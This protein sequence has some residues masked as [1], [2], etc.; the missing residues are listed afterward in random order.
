MA[1]PVA[2]APSRAVVLIGFMGAG[3]STVAAE[4]AR[5]LGVDALDSDELLEARLG[6]S[7]AEEFERRG[8]PSFRAQEEE[9]VCGLLAGAQGGSVISLGGG[10]VLSARVREA[11]EPHL[12]VL[13]LNNR[14]LNQVTWEQR[15]LQG[16]P[17]YPVTQQIPDFPYAKYAELL[18]AY[19]ESAQA[20]DAHAC[21]ARGPDRRHVFTAAEL[22]SSR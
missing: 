8:E 3:K 14:D 19:P 4:L 11:L 16:D 10:S 6:H 2:S 20:P 5:A 12:V 13:V 1:A 22:W 21:R 18:S 15:A 17:M 7:I 9:L